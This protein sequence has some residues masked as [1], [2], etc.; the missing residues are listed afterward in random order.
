MMQIMQYID[1]LNQI[2]Q[3]QSIIK[4][5]LTKIQT[6][7]L[8]NLTN[9]DMKKLKEEAEKE[10]NGPKIK[11]KQ[12]KDYFNNLTQMEVM[13]SL[14]MK[15]HNYLSILMHKWEFNTLPLKMTSPVGCK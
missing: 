5:T 7:I 6:N 2:K 14:K 3:I 8:T 9:I 15:Y 10:A 11:F 13:K 12:L 1:I 4:K